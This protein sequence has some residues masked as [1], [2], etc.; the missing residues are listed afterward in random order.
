MCASEQGRIEKR[1]Y[2]NSWGS[3]EIRDAPRA[4]EASIRHAREILRIYEFTA[5]VVAFSFLFFFLARTHA[6]DSVSPALR[7]MVECVGM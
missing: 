2:A 3:Y 7:K 1:F 6:F 5:V 4:S